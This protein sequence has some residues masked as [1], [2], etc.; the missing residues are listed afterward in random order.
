MTPYKYSKEYIDG[1]EN[2]RYSYT[3]KELKQFLQYGFS[4]GNVGLLLVG[5]VGNILK[6]RGFG[7]IENPFKWLTSI[8]MIHSVSLDGVLDDDFFIK[9]KSTNFLTSYSMI[10]LDITK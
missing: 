2:V 8:N 7:T 1:L 4:E 5:R 9:K 6:Y 10:I 3:Y